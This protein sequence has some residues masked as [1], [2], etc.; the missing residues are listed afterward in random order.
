MFASYG[1]EKIGDDQVW[2]EEL[3]LA[4]LAAASGFDVLRSAEHHFFDY[5]VAFRFGGVPF[6]LAERGLELF[7]RE[8]LPTLKT[9]RESKLHTRLSKEVPWSEIDLGSGFML[10]GCEKIGTAF[11]KM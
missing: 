11:A 2:G 6:D 1:W 8:V 3:R 10:R 7:A 4:Q 5:S 9:R